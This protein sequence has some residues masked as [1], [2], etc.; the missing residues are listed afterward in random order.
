MSA[1]IWITAAFMQLAAA[2]AYAVVGFGVVFVL[3]EL[4]VI[5]S[6]GLAAFAIWAHSKSYPR[7]SSITSLDSRRRG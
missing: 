3:L 5:F 4:F 2:I 1:L 7:E 6:M